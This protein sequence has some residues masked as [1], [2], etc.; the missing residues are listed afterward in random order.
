MNRKDVPHNFN[1]SIIIPITT[2]DFEMNIKYNA[3]FFE[4][5]GIE[6][7]VVGETNICSNILLPII[8]HYPFINWVLIGTEELYAKN[9]GALINIGVTKSSKKYCSVISEQAIFEENIPLKFLQILVGYTN[10]YITNLTNC[11]LRKYEFILITETSFIRKINGFDTSLEKYDIL[12]INLCKRLDKLHIRKLINSSIKISRSQH[13]H[14][15]DFEFSQLEK[16]VNLTDMMT[17]NN[18]KI[19]EINILYDWQ[20]NRYSEE[21]CNEYLKS[22]K[23]YEYKKN[24]FKNRYEKIVLCQSYNEIEFL[25]DFLT[26]MG[27]YFDG[28]ILL[29]DESKDGTFENAKH[30]K[31][32]LKVQKKRIEFDDLTNRNTLLNIASFIQSDW[33]CFMDLD[34]RFDERYVNFFGK[35]RKIDIDC[36]GFLFIHLW[37]SIHEY[38]CS[39]Q[40]CL[41]DGVFV[42]WRMFRNIGRMNIITKQKKL[43]FSVSPIKTPAIVAPVLVHHLGNITKERRMR[44]YHFYKREDIHKDNENYHD[45]LS[46]GNTCF[47]QDLSIK[48]IKKITNYLNQRIY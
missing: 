21:L 29:D 46:D 45:L 2:T 12:V 31:L 43:H 16:Y 44:K 25:T 6:I 10:T 14:P 11:F 33:Y 24:I 8:K 7:I 27:V 3:P 15:N 42:R 47:V 32:L 40:D 4:Q 18:L 37:N 20:V 39:M 28:I 48:K 1:L 5:N 19:K 26:N 35:L 17:S 9:I 23:S 41:I 13:T 30:E 34:E 36:I 22:F 38:N